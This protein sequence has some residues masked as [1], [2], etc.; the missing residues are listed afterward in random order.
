MADNIDGTQISG[1]VNVAKKDMK[2]IQISS[3]LN[4]AKSI[5]G[6]QIGLINYTNSQLGTSI[7][8]LNFSKNKKGKRKV[9]FIVRFPR[10]K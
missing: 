5:K 4:K 6:L 1:L 3:L 2:G 7:G 10:G 8:F 9:S